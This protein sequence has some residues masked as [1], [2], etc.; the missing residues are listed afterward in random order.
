MIAI[1]ALCRIGHSLTDNDLKCVAALVARI[2]ATI[3]LE[4]KWRQS[5][6]LRRLAPTRAIMPGIHG[7]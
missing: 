6:R 5:I 3:E 1:R 4:G 7:I 2:A